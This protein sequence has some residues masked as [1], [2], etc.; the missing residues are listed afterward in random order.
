[1]TGGAMLT[2]CQVCR[3]TSSVVRVYRSKTFGWEVTSARVL[4]LYVLGCR[5]SVVVVTWDELSGYVA[6]G[7]LGY[8][9]Q[10][11]AKPRQSSPAC[12]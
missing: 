8:T 7:V 3:S 1:M 6:L 10:H 12:P 5:P 4:L 2:A 9:S 11:L